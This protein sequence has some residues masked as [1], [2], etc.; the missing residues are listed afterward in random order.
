MSDTENTVQ[1]EDARASAPAPESNGSPG[2]EG[3]EGQSYI[4]QS[5]VNADQ[6]DFVKAGAATDDDIPF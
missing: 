2:N 5:D 1:G 3:G 4:P 6:S